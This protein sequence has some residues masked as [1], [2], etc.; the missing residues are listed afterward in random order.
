MLEPRGEIFFV[1]SVEDSCKYFLTRL[2]AHNHSNLHTNEDYFSCPTN[3]VLK[4]SKFAQ[5]GKSLHLCASR[6]KITWKFF[7]WRFTPECSSTQNFMKISP[8]FAKLR[9]NQIRLQVPSCTIIQVQK[10]RL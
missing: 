10:I 1:K 3:V 5:Q 6:G 4:V 8:R 9:S 2:E 7:P